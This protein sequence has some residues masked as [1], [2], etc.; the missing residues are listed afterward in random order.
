MNKLVGIGYMGLLVL[1]SS[2]VSFP[3]GG[4]NNIR[5]PGEVIRNSDEQN[6]K[7]SNPF[8]VSPV[9]SGKT[10]TQPEKLSFS[11]QE[12]IRIALAHN[13]QLALS[14]EEKAKAQGR[15]TEAQSGLYPQLKLTGSYTRLN[16]VTQFEMGGQTMEFGKLN[17]Y[18]GELGLTQPLY[19]GGRV[20]SG[21]ELARLGI[22]YSEDDFRNAEELI[23]FLVSKAYYDVLLA[24]ETVET[25]RKSLELVKAHLDEVTKIHKQGM[26]ADYDLLRAQVQVS[27]LNTVYLQSVNQL[28][29]ARTSFINI[30]GLPLGNDEQSLTLTDKFV[31][32]PVAFLSEDK[33]RVVAFDN[34][35]DLNQ[36]RLR[37]SMQQKNLD[38]IEGERLPTFALFGNVG[39]SNPPQNVMGGSGWDNYWNVG[40]VVSWS[41]FEGGRIQGKIIQEKSA[42]RQAQIALRDM[43]EK[44]R[45]EVRQALLNLKDAEELVKSQEENVR[46]AEEGLRLARSGYENGVRTQLEVLDSQ[47]ALDSA[48][49]NM[50]GAVYAHILARVMLDKAMGVLGQK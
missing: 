28:H 21:I 47:M 41:L 1:L 26:V 4:E 2:C 35:A 11:L 8:A 39:E 3:D 37:V 12:S 40:G 20:A 29:L 45:L 15:L 10:D 43:E 16:E 30:L 22:K 9:S 31:Y 5:E 48:R 44:V 6:I 34:R 13:R 18:K 36:A 33:V 49:K 38:L 50:A 27:N 17:N 42:L 23:T 25:N 19:T 24:Q 7:T 32:E 46:Q 14:Y